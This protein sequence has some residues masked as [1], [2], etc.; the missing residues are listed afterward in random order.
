MNN[1]VRGIITLQAVLQQEDHLQL[2]LADLSGKI[3]LQ[4]Q[5]SLHT[6]TTQLMLPFPASAADGIYILQVKGTQVSK[7]IRLM[8][9]K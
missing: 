3:L 5:A 2:I 7:N 4:Q 1:P 6:G 8:L 9:L